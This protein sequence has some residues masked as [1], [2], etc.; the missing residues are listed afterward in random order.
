MTNSPTRFTNSVKRSKSTRIVGLCGLA[1]GRVGEGGTVGEGEG[2]IS[3]GVG[4]GVGGVGGGVGGGGGGGGVGGSRGGGDFGD[5]DR[6]SFQYLLACGL[7]VLG[8][9]PTVGLQP[10]Y[11]QVLR[12]NQIS[13]GCGAFPKI[14][15]LQ[16]SSQTGELVVN[17]VE[18]GDACCQICLGSL[19]KLGF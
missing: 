6:P 15:Q 16:H 7:Q 3:G 4:G 12:V 1:T 19:G 5:V 2:E 14:R 13:V 11:R 18:G 10:L 17:L 9:R 8:D